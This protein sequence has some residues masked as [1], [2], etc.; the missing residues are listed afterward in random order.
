[1][2]VLKRASTRVSLGTDTIGSCGSVPGSGMVTAQEK[3]ENKTPS[4]LIFRKKKLLTLPNLRT[5]RQ[6][7]GEEECD[8][9]QRGDVSPLSK[10]GLC[11]W[12]QCS[13]SD[14]T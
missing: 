14:T 12:E 2:F 5:L 9:P 10:S 11:C 4:G 3:N 13:V 6:K 8:L 7:R 1:M